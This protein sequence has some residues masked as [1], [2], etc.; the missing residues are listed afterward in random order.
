MVAVG[1]KKRDKELYPVRTGVVKK[2]LLKQ[3]YVIDFSEGCINEVDFAHKRIML[4][5]HSAI[6]DSMIKIFVASAFVA[7]KN[8]IDVAHIGSVFEEPVETL[9]V[10]VIVG[11]Q[12]FMKEIRGNRKCVSTFVKNISRKHGVSAFSVRDM[13]DDITSGGRSSTYKVVCNKLRA[14]II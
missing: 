2:A 13:Y 10:P 1:V 5:P 9:T 8:V 12:V 3:G 11:A 6:R 14:E 7:K 4:R